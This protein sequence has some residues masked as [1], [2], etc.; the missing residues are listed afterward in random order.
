MIPPPLLMACLAFLLTACVATPQSEPAAQDAK[1]DLCH[2][3]AFAFL[4]GRSQSEIP[5]ATLPPRTR[6]LCHGCAATM[7]YVENRLNLQID[8]AGNVSRVY[9]G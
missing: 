9:C 2:A 5:R 4:T 1:T 3:E 7:D 8:A 6:V